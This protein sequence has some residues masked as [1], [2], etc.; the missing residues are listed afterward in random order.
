MPQKDASA[1][2]RQ[3]FEDAPG[4]LCQSDSVQLAHLCLP[5]WDLLGCHVATSVLCQVVTPHEAPVTHRTHKLLLS[6]VSPAVARQF[7]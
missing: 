3:G 6:R 1:R 7:I 5:A 2:G 4:A